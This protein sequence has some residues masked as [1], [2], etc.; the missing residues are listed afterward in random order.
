MTQEHK[1]IQ[2]WQDK[3]S[4]NLLEVKKEIK[5]TDKDGNE[6]IKYEVGNLE[7]FKIVYE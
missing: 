1:N 2:L 6:L 7:N 4:E 5:T 3:N